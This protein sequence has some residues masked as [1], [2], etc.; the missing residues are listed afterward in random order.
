M[1]TIINKIYLNNN[2][3]VCKMKGMPVDLYYFEGNGISIV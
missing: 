3:A 1:H 2:I